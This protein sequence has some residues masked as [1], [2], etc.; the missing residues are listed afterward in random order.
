MGAS[1]SKLPAATPANRRSFLRR[2]FLMGAGAVAAPVVAAATP[3]SA[4]AK[5]AMEDG[6]ASIYKDIQGH[7]NT[8][9]DTLVLLLGEDARPMPNFQ[10]LAQK[11]YSTFLA[12]SRTLENT[13]V[14]AY[15][16]ALPYIYEPTYVSAAGSIALIEARHAGVLNDMS[17][18][19]ITANVLAPGA[20]NAFDRPLTI[21]QVV[22]LAG[23]FIKD[24][25]G[26][27]PLTFSTT[28]SDD[29]DVDILNFALALEYLEASFYNINVPYFF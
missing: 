24:L 16:G 2:S 29:N 9:V 18:E 4:S 25:N 11:K 28:P 14:G 13:G 19:P 10:G 5:L 12:I 15:L 7:E 23:P 26:G 21:A 17:N 20:D 22:Q 6:T 27:P 3:N 1:D 8:H